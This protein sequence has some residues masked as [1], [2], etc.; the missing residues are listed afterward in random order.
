MAEWNGDASEAKHKP[1]ARPGSRE[2]SDVESGSIAPPPRAVGGCRPHTRPSPHAPV[3][4]SARTVAEVAPHL[5]DIDSVLVAGPLYDAIGFQEYLARSGVEIEIY[6]LEAYK[7][8]TLD[9][10]LGVVGLLL[11]R[12]GERVLVVDLGP[13]SLVEASYQLVTAPKSRLLDVL[14]NYS[15]R[16]LSPLHYRVLYTLATLALVGVDLRREALSKE[17]H[18]FTGGDAVA[19][20]YVLHVADL[21]AQGLAASSCVAA[22]YRREK[23][24]SCMPVLRAAESLDPLGEGAAEG[25]AVAP[26]G[27]RYRVY[28][29]CRLLGLG[30]TCLR[31]ALSAVEPF[32]GLLGT[33]LGRDSFTPLDPEE[34]ACM[35]YSRHGYNCS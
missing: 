15:D 26:E 18:A 2:G 21:A 5:G 4:C 13:G 14:E 9:S 6:P 27:P 30:D 3:F 34:V 22:A 10:L 1:L 29:G 31:E 33:K 19:S 8:P 16:L 11:S 25:V 35:I 20:D 12:A 24:P 17:I 32:S 28:I 23:P 7:A